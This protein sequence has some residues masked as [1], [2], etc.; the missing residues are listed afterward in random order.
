MQRGLVLANR[1]TENQEVSVLVLMAGINRI[2]DPRVAVPGLSSA[3]YD[4]PEFDWMFR[5]VPQVK[6]SLSRYCVET[7]QQLNVGDR[8][9]S[10]AK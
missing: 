7:S 4:D 1:P 8:S 10:M 6:P 9:I 5:S 3:L 2:K